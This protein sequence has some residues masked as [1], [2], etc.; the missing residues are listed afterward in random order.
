MPV[1]GWTITFLRS[2]IVDLNLSIDQAFQFIISCGVVVPASQMQAMFNDAK[3]L[4]PGDGESTKPP[5]AL[6][7]PAT[8]QGTV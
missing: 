8:D 4:P 2:E 6:P 3:A 5:G 7:A 1:T